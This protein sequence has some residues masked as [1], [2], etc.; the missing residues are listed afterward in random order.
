[1]PTFEANTRRISGFSDRQQ[2]HIQLQ[3]CDANG[4]RCTKVQFVCKRSAVDIGEWKCRELHR[5]ET[6]QRGRPRW[7]GRGWAHSACR[8]QDSFQTRARLLQ[9]DV[10]E[11]PNLDSARSDLVETMTRAGHR[12]PQGAPPNSDAQR[13]LA[14]AVDFPAAAPD[15]RHV[16]ESVGVRSW[17]RNAPG[18]KTRN[19]GWGR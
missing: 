10:F 3:I 7:R 9:C 11:F 5:G 4:A 15:G 1:M 17:P 2:L 19:F 14:G 12:R 6:G 18:E 16:L 13:S 8:G